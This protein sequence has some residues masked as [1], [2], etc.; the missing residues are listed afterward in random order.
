MFRPRRQAE[1]IM[2]LWH[3]PRGEE[4]LQVTANVEVG[5]RSHYSDEKL[6]EIG[7]SDIPIS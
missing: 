3:I 1:D 4:A 6:T 5:V 7:P 2:R